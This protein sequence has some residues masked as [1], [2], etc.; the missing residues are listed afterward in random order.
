MS[1]VC[2]WWLGYLL[3]SPIRKLVQDP[4]QILSPYVAEGMIAVDIGCGMGYFSIPMA[5][6]VGNRGKV[7]CVDLQEKML[8]S[9][10]RRA[11]KAGVLEQIEM[12]RAAANSLRLEDRAGAANFVL[13]FAV[14]HEVPDQ[15]RLFSE[16]SAALKTGAKL[17]VAEP[18]GHVSEKGFAA[19]LSIA[20]A[21]GLAVAA[22]PPIRHSHSALLAKA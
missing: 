14:V 22:T 18:K 5:K 1:R 16:I 13:T 9:L 20:Q 2:P 3:A 19:T 4:E 15:A 6:L 11:A 7:I 12:Q 10:K 17:L 8:A 21:N